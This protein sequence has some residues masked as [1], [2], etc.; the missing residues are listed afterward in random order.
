MRRQLLR[1]FLSAL[2]RPNHYAIGFELPLEIPEVSHAQRTFAEKTVAEGQVS[3]CDARERK[4]Q[5]LAVHD[6]D[7]P[8]DG[9]DESG[10][11][12]TRPSHRARPGQVVNDAR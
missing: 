4:R 1:D 6:G 2:R 5:R 7:D 12:Q 3:R 10:A 8:T 11:V 9:A